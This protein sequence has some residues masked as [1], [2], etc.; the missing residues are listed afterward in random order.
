L[1][2]QG[3]AFYAAGRTSLERGLPLGRKLGDEGVAWVA[4]LEAEWARLRWLCDV[5]APS[6]SEHV[7]LWRHAVEGFRGE[8]VIEIARSQ[9]RLAAVLRAAGETREAAE[10]AAAAVEVARRLG[11]RPLLAEIEALGLGVHG[12]RASGGV[13]PD[14]L[15][16]R[17]REVLGLLIEG[18]TNRQIGRQLYI[19]EKTVSV[20]VS[21]IL[22][23]LGV[24]SRTEAAAFARREGLLAPAAD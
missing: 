17:E 18:R 1:V 11:A 5:D 6:E 16:S 21:N 3:G 14:A 15:T 4:R 8:A 10:H 24:R 2:E 19:S 9:A 7:A 20:H 13:H 23:K 12:V 22:A